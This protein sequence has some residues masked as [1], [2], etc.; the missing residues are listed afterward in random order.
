MGPSKNRRGQHG[1]QADGGRAAGPGLRDLF[2][3]PDGRGPG[4]AAGP[5]PGER[6][7][8][9]DGRQGLAEGGDGQGHCLRCQRCGSHHVL[10]VPRH[11]PPGR[12]K[13]EN[14]RLPGHG[15][16]APGHPGKAALPPQGQAA[17]GR[18][19]DQAP[20]LCRH[21]S[22]G[23]GTAGSRA[24]GRGQP[25]LRQRGHAPAGSLRAGRGC[26]RCLPGRAVRGIRRHGPG[27]LRPGPQPDAGLP[28][29]RHRPGHGPGVVD[30]P[31]RHPAPGGRA[32]GGQGPGAAPGRG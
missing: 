31:Q 6:A 2:P 30:H 20:G 24:A 28:G 16:P 3:D 22:E 10:P 18:P 17:G 27:G 29:G 15:E 23:P 9:E 21:L 13:T 11:L 8:G 19:E 14:R 5:G 4:G 25:P 1:T 12:A 32:R 26:L 7:G